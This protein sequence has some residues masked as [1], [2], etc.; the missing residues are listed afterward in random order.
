MAA[1]ASGRVATVLRVPDEIV[2][3]VDGGGTKTDAVVVDLHG[4]VLGAATAGASNWESVGRRAM[5]AAL[6]EAVRGALA[7]AGAE[8][9]GVAASA[10][11]LAGF[12]WP[13]DGAR[14]DPALGALELTGPRMLVND[15]F[16][17]LR[18]GIRHRHGCVSIAGTGGSNV[19]RNRAGATFRTF[20]GSIGEPAGATSVV[21]GA[22]EAIAA[23]AF[24]PGA[25]DRLSAARARRDRRGDS[26][27]TVR[28]FDARRTAPGSGAR[29]RGL[30]RGARRRRGGPRCCAAR[31]ARA[32]LLQ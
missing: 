4:R 20:A 30:H 22:L 13:S 23:R 6:G 2:I 25:R 8:A 11:A 16:A 3:G 9:G 24:R 5:A 17:A 26:R 18:A 21:S 12:D 19:G 1:R 10:F 28:R 15:A 31:S 14:I 29:A 27:S 7:A 32:T